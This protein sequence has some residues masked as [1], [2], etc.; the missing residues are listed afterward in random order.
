EVCLALL[1]QLGAELLRSTLPPI[2]IDLN[3]NVADRPS[4]IVLG[5]I[6][7][8][9][10]AMAS[11]Y[12]LSLSDVIAS[13]CNKLNFRSARGAPTPLHDEDRDANEQFARVFDVTFVRVGAQKSRMY[14]NGRPLG[15]DLT[16]NFYADDGYRFHDVL[17]LALI[18]HLGWSPVVRALM[19]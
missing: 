17:H 12:H 14:L 13:N 11:L 8:H 9:L 15:D 1:W 4:N 2:E 5:E 3:K 6:A 18:A 19:K 7:W 16:D 10:S